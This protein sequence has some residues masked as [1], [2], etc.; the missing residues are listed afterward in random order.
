M[1]GSP[2]GYHCLCP[3]LLGCRQ[4]CLFQPKPTVWRSLRN[5][6][7]VKHRMQK[8]FVNVLL[9]PTCIAVK[10]HL[11]FGQSFFFLC[12]KSRNVNCL[13]QAAVAKAIS[14]GGAFWKTPLSSFPNCKEK[15]KWILFQ[16]AKT[17]WNECFSKLQRKASKNIIPNCKQETY[18]QDARILSISSTFL[19]PC[20]KD[21]IF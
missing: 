11:I 2:H 1:Q 20:W 5:F 13:V 6:Y 4:C 3:Y 12:W 21:N 8:V 18:F 17:N 15:L 14:A 19:F 16:T 10:L 9:W 7:C